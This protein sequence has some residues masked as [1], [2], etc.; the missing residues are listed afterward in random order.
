MKPASGNQAIRLSAQVLA[1]NG[2][3]LVV[4]GTGQTP[5]SASRN[6]LSFP[7]RRCQSVSF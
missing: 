5:G 4:V 2:T 1:F 7:F 6:N 3:T